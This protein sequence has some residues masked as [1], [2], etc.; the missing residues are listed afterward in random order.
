MKALLFAGAFNPVTK[1][2]IELAKLSLEQTKRDCVIFLPSQSH[3]IEQDQRKNYALSANQRLALLRKC[4]E[5][6]PWMKISTYDLEQKE[7]PRTYQS[8]KALKQKGY[9][10]ALLLGDDQFLKMESTWL[11]VDKIAKEFGIVCLER[12]KN[13]LEEMKNSSF[14]MALMPYVTI[15]KSPNWSKT[16]SSS[17]VRLWLQDQHQHRKELEEVLPFSLAVLQEVL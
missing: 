15:I 9:D 8:L 17:Q 3:Y 4:Q 5:N 2:H 10:C 13:V 14:L 12:G 16:I 1:A 11:N 7:Q 6:H